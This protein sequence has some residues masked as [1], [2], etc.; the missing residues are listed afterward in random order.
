LKAGLYDGDDDD[1][2]AAAA[3]NINDNEFKVHAPSVI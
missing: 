3:D 1:A 2:A